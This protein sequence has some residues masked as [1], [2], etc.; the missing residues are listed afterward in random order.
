MRGYIGNKIV[1]ALFA[2]ALISSDVS[3]NA[4]LSTFSFFKQEGNLTCWAACI[5]MIMMYYGVVK[6][7][8]E[9]NLE[10]DIRRLAFGTS[11][12]EP[13]PNLPYD[14]F[15]TGELLFRLLHHP[16]RLITWVPIS[17]D[18]IAYYIGRGLPIIAATKYLNSAGDID[19]TSPGHMYVITGYNGSGNNMILTLADPN[20][21]EPR[22]YYPVRY[23]EFI[24]S[25][26]IDEEG[27]A[28]ERWVGSIVLLERPPYIFTTN[29]E[30]KNIFV[31]NTSLSTKTI[32]AALS[33]TESRSFLFER[34]ILW[35]TSTPFEEQL[36]FDSTMFSIDIMPNFRFT[37]NPVLRSPQALRVLRGAR[38]IR[39][40]ALNI[41]GDEAIHNAGELDLLSL[42][43]SSASGPAIH[44]AGMLRIYHG[45][46][47]RETFPVVTAASGNAIHNTGVGTITISNTIVTA[48]SGNAIYNTANMGSISILNGTV[49]SASGYAA[50]NNASGG[51]I[52]LNGTTEVSTASGNDGVAIYNDNPF[53]RLYL[54]DNPNIIGR[55]EGFRGWGVVVRVTFNPDDDRIYTFVPRNLDDGDVVVVNGANFIDNFEFID[56]TSVF[57]PRGND[58][59]AFSTW[60]RRIIS[61]LFGPSRT[62]RAASSS[63]R[64]GYELLFV[65]NMTY[66]EQVTIGSDLPD[67]TIRSS[68]SSATA[69][70]T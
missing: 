1:F 63:A 68:D 29:R 10:M 41:D 28:A 45:Y 55:I 61:R 4:D 47:V 3:A 24:T 5:R 59:V 46:S 65:D 39:L 26:P 49:S 56:S 53:G 70:P 16:G 44:N 67:I 30:M 13:A 2:L 54:G 38:N 21:R 69:Q 19:S 9:N 20:R 32:N 7:E 64:P 8:D 27:T 23:S 25:R 42:T 35:G 57:V 6:D 15:P 11:D 37:Q 62:I 14:L 58:I 40:M 34:I 52:N 33:R 50:I 17:P 12:T 48:A 51:T 43:V 66:E 36:V 22:F 18:D 31:Y 60:R